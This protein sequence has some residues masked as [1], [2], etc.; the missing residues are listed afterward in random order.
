MKKSNKKFELKIESYGLY[1]KWNRNSR[2][3][4]EIL[5]FTNDIKA[6]PETEFGMILHIKKGKGVKLD[7][8][9]EHP[10]FLD[11]NGK[12]AL[13]FTGEHMVTSNDYY[14]FIGDSIWEPVEDKCGFWAIH[15]FHK[16]IEVAQKQ[17]NIVP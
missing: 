4:P 2:K 1:S 3:L 15:V 12:L 5:K 16:K 9:I 13:E 8:V 6:E 14:F 11:K 17:F 10:A 7:F